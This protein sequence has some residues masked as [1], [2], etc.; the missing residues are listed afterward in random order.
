MRYGPTI[1]SKSS[2]RVKTEE[3]N[4]RAM[5]I[6]EQVGPALRA[7]ISRTRLLQQ[8][9]ACIGSKLVYICEEAG[10]LSSRNAPLHLLVIAGRAKEQPG[11]P[12]FAATAKDPNPRGFFPITK[13]LASRP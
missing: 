1:R 8:R 7:C 5:Y 10:Y 12:G 3:L 13:H 6:K 4:E 11:F 9:P 2:L